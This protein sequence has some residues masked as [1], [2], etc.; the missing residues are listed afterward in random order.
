MKTKTEMFWFENSPFW[1]PWKKP[2]IRLVGEAIQRKTK[3]NRVVKCLLA[4]GG[5]FCGIL[6]AALAEVETLAVPPGSA[7]TLDT[8]S[9]IVI[10]TTG[11]FGTA[12]AVS[13]DK[14]TDYLKLALNK[15]SLSGAGATITFN[16]QA[17][18]MDWR[19]SSAPYDE[20][21]AFEIKIEQNSGNKVHIIGET[22]VAACMGVFYFLQ[23]YTD[24][25]W[26]FPSQY[27]GANTLGLELPATHS[28]TLSPQHIRVVP[29]FHTRAMTG[30]HY[31]D[32]D[33]MIKY[34]GTTGILSSES[35][36]WKSYD[37]FKAMGIYWRGSA[38]HNFAFI[39]PRND[40]VAN[41]PDVLPIINGQPYTPPVGSQ[42]WYPCFTNPETLAVA[43]AKAEESFDGGAFLFS[44]SPEDGAY[45]QN[46]CQCEDCAAVGSLQD[47]YYAFVNAV[48][49]ELENDGYY[50]KHKLGIQA[51]GSFKKP[52]E[53]L[54]L[55]PM[56]MVNLASGGGPQRYAQWEGHASDLGTADYAYG[57]GFWVPQFPLEVIKNDFDV[58]HDA[59]VHSAH[60]EAYPIW[61]F[62]GPKIY[63]LNQFLWHS[64]FDADAGLAAWCNAAFGPGGNQMTSFFE[65]L[66][67]LRDGDLAY[68]DC[69]SLWTKEAYPKEP[70]MSSTNQFSR[71]SAQAI[72]S[73]EADLSA[74]ETAI[75]SSPSK[76]KSRIEMVRAY[77]N[78]TI[79]AFDTYHLGV[80]TF[81]EDLALPPQPD[82][83]LGWWSMDND[84]T[85]GVVEDSSSH[86]RDGTTVN[87]PGQSDGWMG[88]C[89]DCDDTGSEHVS[90]PHSSA[91]DFTASNKEWSVA[92]WAKF[93]ASGTIYFLTNKGS[94]WGANGKGWNVLYDRRYATKTIGFSINN[95]SGSQIMVASGHVG[96]LG[97]DGKWHHVAATADR[98]GNAVVYLDGIQVASGSISSKNSGDLGTDNIRI[99]SHTYSNSLI[100]EYALWDKALTSAE[101]ASLYQTTNWQQC[102]AD[103]VVSG[104]IRENQIDILE[105]HPEWCVGT[106][107]TPQVGIFSNQWELMD[108]GQWSVNHE[109]KSVITT[110]LFQM[111]RQGIPAGSLS[112]PS[113]FQVYQGAYSWDTPPT[114]Y[115][116]DFPGWYPAYAFASM[117]VTGSGSQQDFE[118]GDC[119]L[120]IS[121]ED[122]D[123]LGGRRKTHYKQLLV[124]EVIPPNVEH[125]YD[126][127][128]ATEGKQ[129]T[130]YVSILQLC[131]NGAYFEG[132][133]THTYGSNP[134][135]K[136][137]HISFEPMHV[138]GG[139]PTA[140]FTQS[141][142]VHLYVDLLFLPS[143]DTASCSGSAVIKRASFP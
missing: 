141:D 142:E 70:N 133:Y 135:S 86:N 114:L 45:T 65:T 61:A 75:G 88:L 138:V 102:V 10:T 128:V 105:A 56:V 12:S 81:Q 112:V 87:S 3:I 69:P 78:Y 9:N 85:S 21:D 82:H 59:D 118:T 83:L 23:H 107:T 4:V 96:D 100:D 95:G 97:G 38:S 121:E 101:V 139:V 79:N 35:L 53:N 2:G 32:L 120:T 39:F 55:H 64:N 51:Y 103:A 60:I 125:L 90:V 6:S 129:G 5:A 50:P 123:W 29:N 119:S 91:V 117:T 132:A 126:L 104:D 7:F 22:A 134:E 52:T 37:Y 73:L 130:L 106:W 40:M 122:H 143:E 19:A 131:A 72:D 1:T 27:Q 140:T 74:A 76:H 15:G 26:L 43:V 137:F 17:K 20:Y 41:H 67:A 31:Q 14:L 99:G 77:F 115:A 42:T 54:S 113:E 108:G 71:I 30:F 18:A 48:A 11:S 28:F 57:W 110:A 13:P 8:N 92:L 66:A 84:F 68:G 16:I 24:I 116:R 33:E 93:N 46:S 36:M 44:L 89:A 49:A 127:V 94:P 58:Y 98:D 109:R 34:P 25:M 136:D 63:I 62:D 111:N 80:Q 47:N 124:M